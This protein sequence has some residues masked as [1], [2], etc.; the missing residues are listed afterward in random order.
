MTSNLG[1]VLA[2]AKP[3]GLELPW[4]QR[5]GD[6]EVPLHALGPL[7]ARAAASGGPPMHHIRSLFPNPGPEVTVNMLCEALTYLEQTGNVSMHEADDDSGQT[8]CLVRQS[9]CD[10]CAMPPP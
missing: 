6:S 3:Q 1:T 5:A 8:V 9:T 2:V 4:V 7:L 10:A